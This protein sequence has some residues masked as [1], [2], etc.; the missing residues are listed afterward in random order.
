MK[1]NTYFT[2]VQGAYT[3]VLST[4]ISTAGVYAA[5]SKIT[6]NYQM[7][8]PIDNILNYAISTTSTGF[9]SNTTFSKFTVGSINLNYS[10]YFGVVNL[11]NRQILYISSSTT[12]YEFINIYQV[13]VH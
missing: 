11:T 6:Y 7:N 13:K 10:S 12:I 8:N 9:D 2:F 4:T 1:P 3:N 5:D